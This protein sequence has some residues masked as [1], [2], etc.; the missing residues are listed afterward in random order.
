MLKYTLYNCCSKSSNG[1]KSS[2]FFLCL[3]A[4]YPKSFV[5][6]T[7][8]PIEEPY[9]SSNHVQSRLRYRN[10]PFESWKPSGNRCG[11]RLEKQ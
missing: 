2:R 10:T 6:C 7:D 3:S 1:E 9:D 8:A 5:D 4:D 11:K